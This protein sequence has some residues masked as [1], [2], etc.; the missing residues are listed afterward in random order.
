M[1][2]VGRGERGPKGEPTAGG[3]AAKEEKGEGVGEERVRKED[4]ERG[5]GEISETTPYKQSPEQKKFLD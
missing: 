3:K 5:R 4:M 1:K 2:K